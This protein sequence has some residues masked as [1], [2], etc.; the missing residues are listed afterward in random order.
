MVDPG[1]A[2]RRPATASTIPAMEFGLT[3]FL[4]LAVILIVLIVV[5]LKVRKK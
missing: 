2:W 1:G 3:Y 5:F 4:I